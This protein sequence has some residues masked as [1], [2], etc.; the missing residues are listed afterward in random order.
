[1]IQKF[2]TSGFVTTL[3]LVLGV[4]GIAFGYNQIVSIPRWHQQI[5]LLLF[6]FFWVSAFYLTV[7]W[8]L[9]NRRGSA[10][11]IT[12]LAA[13]FALRFFCI[14]YSIE[15]PEL[16]SADLYRYLWEGNVLAAGFNPYTLAPSS[17]ELLSLQEANK[18]LWQMV[19]HRDIP[20]LYPP[21][22]LAI[23]SLCAG[24]AL[25]YRLILWVM[26][27]GFCLLLYRWLSVQ[28]LPEGRIALYALSPIPIIELSMNAHLDGLFLFPLGIG[29]YLIE[30]AAGRET[31]CRMALAV[32]ALSL[33]CALKQ[34][35][36]VGLA[37]GA[38]AIV[39]NP[40]I[41]STKKLLLALIPVAITVG[42]YYPFI[43]NG[44]GSGS[45]AHFSQHWRFNGHPYYL[46]ENL[47]VRFGAV[48]GSPN[49]RLVVPLSLILVFW[50]TRNRPL[51]HQVALLLLIA[52]F[53]SPLRYPWY[54]LSALAF[55]PLIRDWKVQSLIVGI[56]LFSL[57]SYEVWRHPSIWEVPTS[58]AVFQL[59]PCLLPFCFIISEN[60][61]ALRRNS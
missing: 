29:L 50:Q 27:F 54:T 5:E 22:A 19:D 46:L 47:A 24:D 3:L 42:T 11:A 41:S 23:F 34:T 17:A 6:W 8:A 59:L 61:P 52:Y 30:T 18:A 28:R 15:Q 49:I 4:A 56:S 1:M 38:F 35:A 55:T 53:L 40:A 51:Y 36:A 32:T 26:E 58:I 2:Q 37:V 9:W 33:A 43:L 12:C 14:W 45:L 13:A 25:I 7:T 21:L 31:L 60:L 20:A 57:S 16:L 48:E 39:R 44:G 10:V